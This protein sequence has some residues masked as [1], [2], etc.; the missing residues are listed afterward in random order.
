MSVRIYLHDRRLAACIGRINDRG[1]LR[2]NRTAIA[3]LSLCDFLEGMQEHFDQR[4][5]PEDLRQDRITETKQAE[6][7]FRTLFLE[8]P[9]DQQTTA[10]L[11]HIRV[12]EPLASFIQRGANG[13]PHSYVCEISWRSTHGSALAVYFDSGINRALVI[14]WMGPPDEADQAVKQLYDPDFDWAD[15]F[16]TYVKWPDLGI[17]P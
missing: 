12:I 11:Q 8:Q 10:F 9:Y 6:K 15:L 7:S 2:S 17:L 4:H 1:T 16:S 5:S 14:W 13:A 3:L